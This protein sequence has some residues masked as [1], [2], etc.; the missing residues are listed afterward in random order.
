MEVDSLGGVGVYKQ[1]SVCV[2]VYKHTWVVFSFSRDAHLGLYVPLIAQVHTRAVCKDAVCVI[3]SL[4]YHCAVSRKASLESVQ[5]KPTVT[6]FF[7]FPRFW[8]F[9][10]FAAKKKSK[11]Q[12]FKK[13]FARKKRKEPPTAGAEAGLKAS[14]SSDNVSKTSQNDTLTRSEEDKG[15]G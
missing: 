13:F 5:R 15:S 14:R 11:F 4:A 7:H 8:S 9:L 12:T 2:C 6:S 10:P 1:R 3:A